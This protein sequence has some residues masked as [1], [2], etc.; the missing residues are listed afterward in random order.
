MANHEDMFRELHGVKI[1]EESK[2]DF[3]SKETWAKI[4]ADLVQKQTKSIDHKE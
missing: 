2:M 1:P 4:K 3:S